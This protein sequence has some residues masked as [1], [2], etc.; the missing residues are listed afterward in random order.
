MMFLLAGIFSVLYLLAICAI[1]DFID[2]DY[3]I[4]SGIDLYIKFIK[5]KIVIIPLLVVFGFGS[6]FNT[7]MPSKETAYVMLGAYGVQS[8]TE[9]I[10]KNQEVQQIGKRTLS[11]VETALEKYEK[12]LKAEEKLVDKQKQ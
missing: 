7:L 8:I 12:E 10:G 6:L 9:T 1:H 5:K 11:I 2:N 4:K 3:E